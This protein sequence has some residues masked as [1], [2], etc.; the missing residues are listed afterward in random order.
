MS[1]NHR[2]LL[3]AIHTALGRTR[4][5]VRLALKIR[6]QM[7]AV[8]AAHL[9]DGISIPDN[10]EAWLISKIAPKASTF[11]DV[12]ANTGVWARS[13][14]NAMSAPKKGLLFEPA[15]TALS[16]LNSRFP[17]EISENLLEVIPVAV[18]DRRSEMAFYAEENS[19][20]TSSLI[21]SHSCR[22]AKKIMVKTTTI[23][24][25]VA[26]RGIPFVD[27]VKVDAEGYDFYVLK[28]AEKLLQNKQVGVIQFEYNAPWAYSSSTLF[29]ALEFLRHLQYDVYLLKRDGLYLPEYSLYGEYYAYS[30][31][32]AVQPGYL[33]VTPRGL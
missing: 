1:I 2:N 26:V 19:G 15:P 18:S 33:D 27:F 5:S 24:Y 25:E 12:G 22:G 31:Y 14:L 6:N 4:L 16:Q 28:G 13:F 32:I 17:S 9:N 20:E 7:D 23:D 21:E 29:A 8:I 30:N 11:I 3:G 10:G